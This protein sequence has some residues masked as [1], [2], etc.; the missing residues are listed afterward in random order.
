MT[1]VDI[2]NDD[3]QISDKAMKYPYTAN[4][5]KTFFSPARLRPYNAKEMRGLVGKVIEVETGQ[6]S[7]CL[8]VKGR[9]AEFLDDCDN[10]DDRARIIAYDC[11]MLKHRNTIDNKPAGILEHRENGKWVE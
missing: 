3:I 9:W 10:E 11:D 4:E 7:L 2:E 5:I 6:F 8:R 1:G